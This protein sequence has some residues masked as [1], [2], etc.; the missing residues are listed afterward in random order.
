MHSHKSWHSSRRYSSTVSAAASSRVESLR[1]DL[2]LNSEGRTCG[3][4]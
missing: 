1:C 3:I 4:R 2:R